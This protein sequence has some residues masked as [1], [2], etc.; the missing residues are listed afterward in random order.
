MWLDPNSSIS[1]AEA[2]RSLDVE[3]IETTS[4]KHEF[5]GVKAS[6][7]AE[8]CGVGSQMHTRRLE[9]PVEVVFERGRWRW[10]TGPMLELRER[11]RKPGRELWKEG[12]PE[13]P[14]PSVPGEKH[15]TPQ[16]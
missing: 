11:E 6:S 8:R 1:V 10:V 13:Y 9:T 4:P 2:I 12:D 14:S 15:Y 7:G 16:T 3:P 5:V